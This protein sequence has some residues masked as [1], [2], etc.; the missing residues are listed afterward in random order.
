VGYTS[1]ARLLPGEGAEMGKMLLGERVRC[2]QRRG[3]LLQVN[4][5][6]AGKGF[7]ICQ[8]CGLVLQ[9]VTPHSRPVWHHGRWHFP[10][11]PGTGLNRVVLVHKFYSEVA[12]LRINWC[13]DLFADPT[14]KAGK[15]S[16]YSLGYS[17]LRASAV[18][19]QVDPAE[20][21]M[22]V[23]PYQ[24]V[25]GFGS[26]RI[27]GDIYIYD[28]LPG[29]AGYARAIA[30]N[31]EEIMRLAKELLQDCPEN[32][33]TACYRCLLD[34][35]NQRFHGLLDRR[36]AIDI[37]EYIIDGTRPSLSEETERALLE[38]LQLFVTE[39]SE[40]ELMSNDT[41]GVFAVVKLADARKAI[42]KPVHTL[43]IGSQDCRLAL[44]SQTGIVSFVSAPAIELERQPFGIWQQ[45]IEEA[46]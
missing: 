6:E 26:S 4:T 3:A 30:A 44:V 33:E 38:R 16:L 45:L 9:N 46:R 32:C 34:Y 7:Q 42:I 8:D 39:D 13:D 31:L 36:L 20:L 29:G 27:G 17:L 11:C 22:G 25:D 24:L 37:L 41:H 15:A 1:V 2:H 23:Q 14:S 12:L 28:T 40:I 21:A 19:L 35:N 43:S 5:G 18:F 10:P